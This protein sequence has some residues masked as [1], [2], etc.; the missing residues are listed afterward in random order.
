MLTSTQ[1]WLNHLTTTTT[2][3][4]NPTVGQSARSSASRNLQSPKGRIDAENNNSS[5]VSDLLHVCKVM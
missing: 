5:C 1:I 3:E 2:V 4:A